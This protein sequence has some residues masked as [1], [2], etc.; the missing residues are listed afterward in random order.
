KEL[1]T[2]REIFSEE[3]LRKIARS[4]SIQGIPEIPED[5]K[6]LFLTALEI[7]PKWHVRMQATFQKYVDNGVSK[8]VNLPNEATEEDVR[9]MFLQA[10]NLGCKGIT[11]YRYGSRKEQVLYIGEMVDFEYA[12]GCISG[13]CSF[14]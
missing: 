4:G 1:L 7:D 11:V 10:F 13:S 5:I 8:T 3:L 12:G 6:K 2:I 14:D 9:T